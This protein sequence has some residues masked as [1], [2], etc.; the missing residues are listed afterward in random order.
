MRNSFGKFISYC[1][2]VEGRLYTTAKKFVLKYSL[3]RPVAGNFHLCEYDWR[4][5]VSFAAFGTLPEYVQNAFVD[6]G[7]GQR[8]RQQHVQ[9][10]GEREIIENK[11][12]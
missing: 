7:L 12:D 3:G 4:T 6:A 10:L 9:E 2:E 8:E 11:L 5:D 1:S